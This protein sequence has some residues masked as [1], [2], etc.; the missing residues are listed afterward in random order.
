MRRLV[1]AALSFGSVLA[2]CGGNGGGDHGDAPV[3]PDAPG[4]TGM[5]Y[6]ASWGPVTVQPGPDGENT[7]CITVRLSNDHDI[8]VHQ[9]HN[10]LSEG[11]H[12][13]IVYRDDMDTVENTTPT[14][15]QPFTGALNT[16]G[17]VAPIMITQ[18][19]DDALT[20]PSGVA[21]TLKAHQMVRIEM[22]FIDTQ[23]API[24][25]TG[26]SDFYE[27][28]PSTITD[29]ANILFVGSPDIDIAA[30]PG[31]TANVHQFFQVPSYV[32]LSASHIFA[33]TGHTHKL[34]TDVQVRVA[35]SKTGPMTPV[36]SPQQ[37]SWSEP[38]TET[39]EP[40][41]SVPKNGGLDFECSYVNSTTA[42]VTFG[43]SANDEMCF[44]WAYYYP[45]QGSKVCVHTDK[46]GGANGLNVCC[47]GDSLCSL[48]EMMF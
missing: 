15:C 2:A 34:G 31:T 46:Y 38:I 28:D 5:S 12:H 22:H 24:Q 35:P 18:K 16:S 43:E 17:M 6:R 19:K 41:F 25:V 13:M 47:P 11:S 32:D 1:L 20:L 9:L 21:Y 4:L 29:E 33:I 7:Q 27:A 44:F 23:D 30:G 39:Q 8:K 45:S 42:P 3:T 10:V 48:I 36:Y 26:T 40:G 37:F 14:N